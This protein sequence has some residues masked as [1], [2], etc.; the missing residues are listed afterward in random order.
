MGDRQINGVALSDMTREEQSSEDRQEMDRVL[1]VYC[2]LA[3]WT[4]Q[5]RENSRMGTAPFPSSEIVSS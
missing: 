1:D 5:E 2:A 4:C 3:K